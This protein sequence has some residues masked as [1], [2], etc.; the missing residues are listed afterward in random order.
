MF[1]SQLKDSTEN[2]LGSGLVLVIDD[3]EDLRSMIDILLGARGIEVVGAAGGRQALQLLEEDPSFDAI[4]L[5]MVMPGMDGNEVLQVLSTMGLNIPVVLATG[6]AP[7]E[8]DPAA[9]AGV[10]A[11]LRK[12]FQILRSRKSSQQIL[13]MSDFFGRYTMSYLSKVPILAKLLTLASLKARLLTA[14]RPMPSV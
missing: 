11:T 3:E 7:E 10:S 4:I 5:D 2:W 9:R 6:Y 12:P 13:I 8:L 14:G 1:I